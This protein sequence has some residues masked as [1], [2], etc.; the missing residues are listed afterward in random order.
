MANTKG[1]QSGQ[2]RMS[3]A[4][5]GTTRGGLDLQGP[6]VMAA[7]VVS[8]G[9]FTADGANTVVVPATGVTA[10]SIIMITIKTVGG[11]PSPTQP[12]VILL[13]PGVGF[14]IKST[15]LDTSV[16]NWVCLG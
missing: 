4:N 5:L 8:Q 10:N 9:T 11:T 2:K 3:F 14:S 12:N 1:P 6:A 16:Y 13:N 7:L 15:A